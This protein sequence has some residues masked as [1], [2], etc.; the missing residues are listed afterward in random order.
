MSRPLDTSLYEQIKRQVKARVSSWPSAYA[1]GQVVREYKRRGGR[2]AGAKLDTGNLSRW[3]KED[4]RNVCERDSRG[5]YKK[6]GASSSR[7]RQRSKYPYCRPSKRVSKSTPRTIGEMS[8]AELERMCR[9]KR[10]SVKHTSSQ[11]RVYGASVSSTASL[12]R[13]TYFVKGPGKYKYTAVL[14][15]GKRVNFGHRDYQQYRDS[16]PRRLGGGLWSSK[17]HG[18]RKRR[19]SYRKRHGGVRTSTGAKAVM[20]KYSPAWF[21][22]HYLW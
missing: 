16:V 21:S 1:S 9:K 11:T 10:R 15:D 19:D 2:Y 13:G 8:S 18:D 12:A 20:K 3:Y 14:P 5:S 4:W 22:Y 7:V 17:D 6:C